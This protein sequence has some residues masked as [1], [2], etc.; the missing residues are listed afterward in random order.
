MQGARRRTGDARDHAAKDQRLAGATPL[1]PVP[2]LLPIE[3][4]APPP[5]L[6][7]VR[8]VALAVSAVAPLLVAPADE[9][10][11]YVPVELQAARL[12]AIAPAISAH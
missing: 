1:L 2:A 8:S 4:S 10:P 12:I 5:L 11:E 6:P 9:L 7:F 3:L